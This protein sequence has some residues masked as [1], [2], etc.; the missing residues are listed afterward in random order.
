MTVSPRAPRPARSS[1]RAPS[2]RNARRFAFAPLLLPCLAAMQA[3]PAWSQAAAPLPPAAPA[4]SAV[5]SERDGD[6]AAAKAEK[7]EVVTVTATRRR[8]PLRDV[9]LRVET[10]S[11]EGLERAGAGSLVDYVGSLPG[12]DVSSD[13]GP[14]RGQVSIRGINVGSAGT[15][16]VGTY[17]DEV[18]Y[19]SS[20]AFGGAAVAALDMSLLDLHHIELLRG[21]QGT[22]YGAGAMGG[23][24]KYVTN[25]PDTLE[26]SGKVGLGV[27]GIKGGALGHTEN[28]VVNVP[29]SAGVAALRVAA[30]NDHDGGYIKASGLASGKHVNDGDT[31]G[32][33]VSLLLEPMSKMKVRLSAVDQKIER[34]GTGV[35]QY[36]VATGQPLHGD[37]THDLSISEPYSI[38]TRLLSADVDYDF[39]WA[40][41]NAIVSSQRFNGDTLLD[42]TEILGGGA[43]DFVQLDN[44]TKLR[45]ETQEL[46]LTS[47]RGTV[48]WLI[49]L[50][51]NKERNGYNQ[52]LWGRPTGADA[53]AE[54][55]R[56]GQPASYEENAV[57][58]DVTWNPSSALSFTLGARVARNKQAYETFT[59]DVPDF[60]APATSKDR[61]NTYLITGRYSL[62]KQ[63][64]VYVRAASGYRP[65]GPNPQAIDENGQVIPG[66][67]TSFEADTLWSY[68]AGYKADLLDRRLSLEVALFDI[69]W[70]KL[71]QPLAFGATTVMGNAG[72][73]EVKGLELASRYAINDDW[74]LEGSLAWTDGKLKEDAP[75]L[76]PS[77]ARLPNSAK[78]SVSLGARYN[79]ALAG[80][81]SYASLQVRHV[82]KRNAG[83][84]SET[85]SIPNFVMPA[86]T[87][88]D[89]Q[90]GMDFGAWQLSAF[91]RNLTD[92][93]A[94]LGAD[95]AL[96]AFGGPLRATPAQPRTIG[97][98]VNYN[99]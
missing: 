10:I 3:L 62:D 53:D 87:L 41:L 32:G 7:L 52:R 66:A 4:S 16:T 99:F 43:F 51:H 61:S 23:L 27:R 42:A 25:E 80:K 5:P 76:G 36:D 67:P 21:P 26:F 8:E 89:A 63:S 11:A 82:G 20:T 90:W 84:D 83:Y 79:F 14:G 18:A 73:A 33:R 47:A 37:L 98:S 54:L 55:V 68:E 17:V 93:R 45:K 9:P 49:G 40:R 78:L 60:P 77:G 50:Y 22:L 12:V 44:R 75:A 71:Q 94:I 57:Y 91:V 15:A 97:A 38:R 48:E 29:L 1:R 85:T 34:N 64:S 70:S 28:A 56:V 58:G 59:N 95:T 6:R 88:V 30:F 31:R 13:G 86:Y 39:G 46:R 69:R 72:K 24:L 92:K 74:R 81:P 96:T 2:A 35:V 65:G 19:G